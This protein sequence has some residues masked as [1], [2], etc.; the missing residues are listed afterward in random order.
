MACGNEATT[1]PVT[2]SSPGPNANA[3]AKT[4]CT[5]DSVVL[6]DRPPAGEGWKLNGH[7]QLVLK[8]GIPAS[9]V[10]QDASGK[11]LNTRTIDE[12]KNAGTFLRLAVCD[13]GG[14]GATN[15]PKSPKENEVE[16]NGAFLFDTYAPVAE[17]EKADLALLCTAPAGAHQ[18]PLEA[19]T[20]SH[21]QMIWLT[22]PK[23][24]TLHANAER[25]ALD[26]KDK[27]AARAA[28]SG[29]GAK[30][31]ALAAEAGYPSCYF[32][33]LMKTYGSSP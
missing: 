30:F 27:V 7:V 4:G 21:Q 11:T 29:E 13:T 16:P 17:D 22:S 15:S 9:A 14:A 10:A 31:A 20:S 12:V 1:P 25:P 33:E 6:P 19:F 2:P 32:A 24:R 26:A 3:N 8:D 23:W 18:T 5:A 28:A